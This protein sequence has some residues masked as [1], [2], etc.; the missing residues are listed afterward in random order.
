[1]STFFTLLFVILYN[2]TSLIN[3]NSNDNNI[4]KIIIDTNGGVDDAFA[5]IHAMES[6]NNHLF[7]IKAITTLSTQSPAYDTF[8]NVIHL[9]NM[10]THYK[11]QKKALSI[12]IGK[13]RNDMS[14]TDSN[15]GIFG[16]SRTLNQFPDILSSKK[17]T[18]RAFESAS[19]S[20]NLL[21]D[22][23]LLHPNELT[24][25]AT[26]PLTNL[27]LAEAIH[28]GI[29]SLLKDIYIA[30]GEF[31]N[32]TGNSKDA[33]LSEFNFNFDSNALQ[34]VFSSVEPNKFIFPLDTSKKLKVGMRDISM[35]YTLLNQDI[36]SEIEVCRIKMEKM[37]EDELDG[38]DESDLYDSDRSS[39]DEDDFDDFKCT[40]SGILYIFYE[41]MMTEL[42]RKNYMDGIADGLLIG[43]A[44]I[45]LYFLYPHLYD[46]KYVHCMIN[47]EN[48]MVHYD[49]GLG[50]IDEDSVVIPNCFVNLHVDDTQIVHGFTRDAVNMI[51]GVYM[52][53][54][55]YMMQQM[56]W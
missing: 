40:Q 44:S 15:D 11:I 23:I 12:P 16:L 49:K 41:K 13:S 30:G 14:S 2:V 20:E 5:I 22:T 56:D 43:E 35:I 33:A 27:Y 36:Q 39:A 32:R 18:L 45:I 50:V 6:F 48:G 4:R 10:T 51:H 28:P 7:D 38:Y 9:M 37:G 52:D 17:K 53:S 19:Y 47:A 46:F 1:M 8:R 54:M 24:L 29:L 25:I 55:Q 34:K 21:V 26:G 42:I 3:A 31:L